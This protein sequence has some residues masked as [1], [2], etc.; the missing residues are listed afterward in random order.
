M[1]SKYFQ[2]YYNYLL[3]SINPMHLNSSYDN[4]HEE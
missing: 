1:N 3:N 2:N 4:C